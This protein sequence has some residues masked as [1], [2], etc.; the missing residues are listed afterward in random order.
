MKPEFVKFECSYCGNKS[1]FKSKMFTMK[2]EKG[3]TKHW[4]RYESVCP[5]CGRTM[6]VTEEVKSNGNHNPDI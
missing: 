6:S 5:S 4:V 2:E 3:S 1:I